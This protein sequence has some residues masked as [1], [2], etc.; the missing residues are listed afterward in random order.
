MICSVEGR[1]EGDAFDR[2][3]NPAASFQCHR[4]RCGGSG[5]VECKNPGRKGPTSLV[6]PLAGCF[7][8][9]PNRGDD[10]SNRSWKSSL[11]WP[12]NQLSRTAYTRPFSK[13]PTP[14]SAP[15]PGRLKDER[16][17]ARRGAAALGGAVLDPA[18]RRSGGCPCASGRGR[19]LK[20]APSHALLL[21]VMAGPRDAPLPARGQGAPRPSM[22]AGP[23]W[24]GEGLSVHGSPAQGRG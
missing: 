17:R 19:I 5:Y 14:K 7:L 12:R 22:D 6:A 20:D 11:R 15:P 2:C 8:L 1:R 16:W 13:K 24:L 3:S 9:G 21:L 4:L 10:D 18:G 23:A